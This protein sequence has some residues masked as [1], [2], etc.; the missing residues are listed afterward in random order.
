MQYIIVSLE[1]PELNA[2]HLTCN[3]LLGFVELGET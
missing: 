2:N 1:R 3:L